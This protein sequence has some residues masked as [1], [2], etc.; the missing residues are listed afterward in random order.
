MK[1]YKIYPGKDLNPC[2]EKNPEAVL[3]WLEESELGE[4]IKIKILEMTEDE[5]EKLPEYTGP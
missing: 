3:I 4:E 2:C 5:Y 1:V